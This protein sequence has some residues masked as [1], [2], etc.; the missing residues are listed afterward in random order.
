MHND[1][2]RTMFFLQ[3]AS[4]KW[5]RLVAAGHKHL[6]YACIQ[7]RC[8]Y[9]L[10]PLHR[11]FVARRRSRQEYAGCLGKMTIDRFSDERKVEKNTLSGSR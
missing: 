10:H 5:Q 4:S 11:F 1:K 9:K 7:I 8:S 6:V 2:A 3:D